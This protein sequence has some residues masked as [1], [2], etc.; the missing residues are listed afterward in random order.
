MRERA[1]RVRIAA[2]QIPKEQRQNVARSPIAAPDFSTVAIIGAS[3]IQAASGQRLHPGDEAKCPAKGRKAMKSGSSN[4]FSA[5]VQKK[6]FSFPR[7]VIAFHPLEF[8]SSVP[9]KNPNDLF[10]QSDRRRQFRQGSRRRSEVLTY[11]A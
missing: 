1:P 7:Q 3:A 2:R 8:R 11:H 10:P 4:L 5:P 9:R 6:L